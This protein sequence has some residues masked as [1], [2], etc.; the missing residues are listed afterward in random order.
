MELFLSRK[1][2]TRRSACGFVKGCLH[3]RAD[4]QQADHEADR[5][6]EVDNGMRYYRYAFK[7][8]GASAIR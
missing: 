4:F 3:T 8:P 1:Q 5:D 6:G 7:G 2:P